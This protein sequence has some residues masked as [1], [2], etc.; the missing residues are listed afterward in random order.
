MRFGL[1]SRIN[2]FTITTVINCKSIIIGMRCPP[3][4]AK[5]ISATLRMRTDTRSSIVL[6]S[7]S[8]AFI[9]DKVQQQTGKNIYYKSTPALNGK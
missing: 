5:K 4:S 6:S 7:E 1:A 3:Y 8:D 9:K 2:D